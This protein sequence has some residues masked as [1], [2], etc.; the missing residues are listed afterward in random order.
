MRRGR[1]H[2]KT[3]DRVRA[4]LTKYSLPVLV[5]EFL[6]VVALVSLALAVAF[7]LTDGGRN[8]PTLLEWWKETALALLSF[9]TDLM[10]SPGVGTERGVL[11]LVTAVAGVVLPALFIAAIVLKL[12]ISPKLFVM[13]EKVVAMATEPD[14]PRKSQLGSHH[15]A[16][17][18][19]SSTRFELL[20]VTF[21]AIIRFEQAEANGTS[22]LFHRELDVANPGYPIAR[23]H[24]PF[25]IAIRIE[26][27]DWAG[28][29]KDSLA[30]LQGFPVGPKAELIVLIEGSIPELGTEFTEAHHTPLEASL[31]TAAYAGIS[32]DDSR[33][34][35][36]WDGWEEFDEQ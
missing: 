17:R 31:S 7:A 14:H 25:T 6:A 29:S 1:G 27:D 13:R 36:R 11:Q 18:C 4:F 5:A 34:S 16:V 35:R 26:D 20:N 15:L 30:K 12:F 8:P 23:P 2:P 10:L 22:T 33:R 19:Y 32:V 21:S 28:P 9:P 3:T 24:V